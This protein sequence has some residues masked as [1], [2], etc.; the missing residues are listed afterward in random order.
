MEVSAALQ[1][2]QGLLPALNTALP[3]Q[4]DERY[5]GSPMQSVTHYSHQARAPWFLQSQ[6]P[7]SQERH[8]LRVSS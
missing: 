1:G 8:M 3:S 4:V 5:L 7:S 6:R 2:L